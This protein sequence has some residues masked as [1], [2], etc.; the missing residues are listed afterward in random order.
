MNI[1]YLILAHKDSKQIGRL[2]RHL[3][4]SG[5]VLVHVDKKSNVQEFRQELGEIPGVSVISKYS[6]WWAGWSMVRAYMHMFKQTFSSDKHYDRFV[7]MTGQDYPL[8]TP[9][10][11][12][13]EFEN[14]KDT[15]YIMAYNVT[16]SPIATD[17]NKTGKR[18]YFDVPLFKGKFWAKCYHSLTY[19]LLT[20]PSKSKDHHVP[21]AGKVVDPY[22]GQMLSSF[23]RKGV[24]LLLST[25]ENDDKFNARMKRCHAAVE[26]YWQT[27]I[28]NSD[29]RGNTVQ[30]GAEHEITEHFGWAP[31]HYHNYDVDTSVYTEQDFE[32]LKSSGYMFCRKVVP[33]KS[34]ALMDKIDGWLNEKENSNRQ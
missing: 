18:W 4:K 31:H 30:H 26:L 12:R 29:L 1:V 14:N 32:Q 19:R 15:E 28:F 7:M 2:C 8:M 21:L 23:T 5:D 11:I 3:V 34:D 25:Y 20:K 24:E 10:E 9:D 22:F 6:V 33:G 17:K 13:T 16:T 27:V